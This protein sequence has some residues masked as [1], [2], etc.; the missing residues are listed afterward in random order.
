ME[1]LMLRNKKI[2]D[3]WEFIDSSSMKDL[4]RYLYLSGNNKSVKLPANTKITMIANDKYYSYI[5]PSNFG[6][7]EFW[8]N[9]SGELGITENLG[10]QIPLCVFK[11][12]DGNK[13]S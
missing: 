3:K 11:D 10:N 9:I 5:I 1:F 2:S 6:T 8:N 13:Y 7:E 12:R 4:R